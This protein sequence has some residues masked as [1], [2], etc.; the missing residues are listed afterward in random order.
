MKTINHIISL[1]AIIF[2]SANAFAQQPATS[3]ESIPVHGNCGMCKKA[4]EG[5]AKGAG[6]SSAT[7]DEKS[8]ML[9][10]SYDGSKT[11]ALLIQ[12]AVAG[13]GYDTR[14]VKS[15]EDAYKSLPSCCQYE[16]KQASVQEKVAM[17]CD[18][19]GCG[20]DDKACKDTGCCGG[21]CKSTAKVDC[22][23]GKS[24]DKAASSGNHTAKADAMGCCKKS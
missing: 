11:T 24:C 14:D 4:I 1:F 18:K 22:C 17:C 10:I 21:S 7:W 13:S 16:R 8:K 2:I 3:S 9:S 5:A 15:T 19:E 23:A 20:K 12:Q 6:A